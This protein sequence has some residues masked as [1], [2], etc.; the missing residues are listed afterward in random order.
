LSSRPSSTFDFAAEYFI[1]PT[2]QIISLGNLIPVFRKT[3]F[4][5]STYFIFGAEGLLLLRDLPSGLV[6]SV[7]AAAARFDVDVGV[8]D[9]E[10]RLLKAFHEV[11]F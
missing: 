10:T 7:P 4:D 9:L 1:A 8:L 6:F 2:A 3:R 5:P 11:Y